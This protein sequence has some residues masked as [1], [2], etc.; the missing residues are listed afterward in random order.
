MSEE[1]AMKAWQDMNMSKMEE[2]LEK[3]NKE[4]ERLRKALLDAG[5]VIKADTIE[6]KAEPAKKN[7][8]KLMASRSLSRLSLPL[9]SSVLKRLRSK[10][11]KQQQL[12][13]QKKPFP[14]SRKV[15]QSN[16]SKQT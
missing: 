16:W 15:S 9:F 3:S 10:S 1:E 2:D 7:L 14:T 4:N 13:R 6:K 5:Y 12:L 11:L 8:S